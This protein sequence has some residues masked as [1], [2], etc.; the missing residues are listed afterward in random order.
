MRLSESFL[1][2]IDIV[3][4]PAHTSQAKL[5]NMIHECCKGCTCSKHKYLIVE[6]V[7]HFISKQLQKPGKETTP[8]RIVLLLLEG[9]EDLAAWTKEL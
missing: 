4:P 9:E 7:L 3:S 1:G 5:C 2:V 6:P 8:G